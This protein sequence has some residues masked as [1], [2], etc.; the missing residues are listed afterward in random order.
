MDFERICNKVI[1]PKLND[2]LGK[3]LADRLYQKARFAMVEARTDEQ[4]LDLFVTAI[5]GDPHFLGMWGTAQAAKQ[6]REWR[7]L[8]K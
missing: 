4:R 1:R 5:S 3:V 2:M 6:T 8:L 7:G